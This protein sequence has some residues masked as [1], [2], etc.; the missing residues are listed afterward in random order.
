V[1]IIRWLSARGLLVGTVDSAAQPALLAATS[2]DAV[3]GGFYGPQWP[4]NAGGPPGIQTLWK[5]LRDSENASRVWAA[6]E[7]LTGVAF[8]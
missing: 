6:S 4:G 3:N 8:G 2:P 7:E 5:P 1:R